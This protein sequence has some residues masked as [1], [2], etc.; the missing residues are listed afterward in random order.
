MGAGIYF[1]LQT[2]LTLGFG[3]ITTKTRPGGIIAMIIRFLDL[4]LFGIIIEKA[5]YALHLTLGLS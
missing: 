3:D 4:L 5:T 1:A 2:A